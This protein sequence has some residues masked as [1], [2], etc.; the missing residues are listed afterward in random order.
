MEKKRVI[1]ENLILDSQR[2]GFAG[3]ILFS[4][5]TLL[6]SLIKK[7]TQSLGG[8]ANIL[9]DIF[10]NL[11]YDLTILGILFGII[12]SFILGFILFYL[13]AIIYNKLP[14]KN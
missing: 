4:I 13:F 3:A 10:G 1:K 14:L 11:G 8:T 2:I 12:D 7:F 5:I 9:L 6:V